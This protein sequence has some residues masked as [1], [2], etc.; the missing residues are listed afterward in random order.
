MKGGKKLNRHAAM[1]RREHNQLPLLVSIMYI[2]F[3]LSRPFA[4]NGLCRMAVRFTPRPKRR[5][6]AL[7]AP[8][9]RVDENLRKKWTQKKN[10]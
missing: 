4:L 6:H 1:G 3:I 5:A 10:P 9:Q 7:A 2:L 8:P